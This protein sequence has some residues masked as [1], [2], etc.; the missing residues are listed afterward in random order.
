M[1][2][3]SESHSVLVSKSKVHPVSKHF[4]K[5]SMFKF[6]KLQDSVMHSSKQVSELSYVDNTISS[7]HESW[8]IDSTATINK[9]IIFLLLVLTNMIRES[10][11]F[12]LEDLGSALVG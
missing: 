5:Q 9:N 6:W 4:A 7:V 10:Y 12:F 11:G 3:H 8:Q 2:L 1:L